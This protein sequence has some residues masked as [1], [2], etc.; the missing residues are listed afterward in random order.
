MTCS[1]RALW[2]HHT[3]LCFALCG[4]W[5]CPNTDVPP[6]SKT[7]DTTSDMTSE[8]MVD[9]DM[10]EDMDTN[11]LTITSVLPSAGP[12]AGG[13]EVLITGTGFGSGL[14][15]SFGSVAAT[16]VDVRSPT[17]VAAVTPSVGM[18]GA[19]DVKLE[20]T[21]GNT[22]SSP[23][24]F[25][26]EGV[27]TPV[28][29]RLQAQ[30]PVTAQVNMAAPDLYVVVFADG[31]TEGAGQGNGVEVE[32][33]YGMGM[34]PA[35]Y[36]YSAA[37]YNID[38]DGLMPGDMAN[39]EYGGNFTVATAGT[40]SYAARV[41]VP[42]IDDQWIY[43][44]LDGSG[45]GVA[46]DQLGVLNVQ[47]ATPAK[48]SFCRLQNQGTVESKP[49]EMTPALYALVFAD[50][51]TNGDGQGAMIE[52]ELG[53]G[54]TAA[55][56]EN[57][58]YAA[59]TYNTDKDG[60]A[61][62]D[63]ANDEYGLAVTIANEGSY[64][65]AARFRLAGDQDW[66]YCDVD[67]HDDNDPFEADQLGQISITAAPTPT[68][69]FCQVEVAQ[70]TAKPNET[71]TITALVYAQGITNMA[72]QGAGVTGELV[73]GDPNTSP[74]QWTQ[75]IQAQY[76]GDVD[77]LMQGDNANDRYTVSWTQ[78]TE[79]T[80]GYAYRFSLDGG[81]NWSWCDTQGNPPMSFDATAIGQLTVQ[82]N[83]LPD[84]CAT[85]YPT[86]LTQ[87]VKGQPL[88]FFGR[89]YE[90]GVTDI[91]NNNPDVK[92][93]VWMGPQGDDPQTQA[94]NFT[95]YPATFKGVFAGNSDQDEYQAD[96]TPNASG[97]YQFFFRFSVDNGASY[98]FCDL[99]GVEVSRAFD[100]KSVGAVEVVDAAEDAP[101]YCHVFQSNV[102]KSLA[103]PA[104]PIFTMEVYE[105]GIT[106]GM[107]NGAK[108]AELTVE[109]GYGDLSHNPAIPTAYTW[110]AAPFAR[111]NGNNYE[112]EA[113]P[114]YAPMMPPAQG[115]Y[116]VV[117]RVKKAADSQWIYCDNFNQTMD[118]LF[119]RFSRLE[120]V[121]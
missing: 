89:V 23:G 34:D 86:A 56:Y 87:A 39:D 117:A 18:P 54:D 11:D 41:K 118:F 107:D 61:Q 66:F 91:S 29:C 110:V 19:V 119:D 49:G 16:S 77:G 28:F 59:M 55:N 47:E 114:P 62:G 113:A 37:A 26:Y 84:F 25:T 103:D 5:G 106:D 97:S 58:T 115:S 35:Q 93:E 38:K 15:V 65:Y 82:A 102:V 7:P 67:G 81:Q 70:A 53:W 99:G 24:A 12:V 100:L 104:P 90:P 112:Y 85:Q 75:S 33:G 51:I 30:S 101:D 108:A 14:K 22:T 96:V 76:D 52:A 79:G 116:G 83:N 8:D 95:V 44:D 63:K 27:E 2:V 78:A 105:A 88:S 13:T 20:D 121:P 10:T 111:V 120:I 80:Y 45:N 36:Q 72:G 40:Y 74:M 92:A 9:G 50:G 109:F 4:L 32:L 73:W 98:Q 57:F 69:S 43:C 60:L 21:M 42:S 6:P 64:F 46:P 3:I 1:K 31:I 17:Q 71:S 48:I 68:I 94:A